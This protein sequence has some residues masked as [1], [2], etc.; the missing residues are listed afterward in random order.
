MSN[1][2][3]ESVNEKARAVER[4]EIEDEDSRHFRFRNIFSQLDQS[5]QIQHPSLTKF[6]FG[7]RNT[8]SVDPPSEL[9]SRV[10]AFLPEISSSNDELTRRAQED[11]SSV[12][13][14]NVTAGGSYIQMNLGL[15]VFEQRGGITRST[16]GNIAAA[17]DQDTEMRLES[18]SSP[19]SGASDSD[20][21]SSDESDSDGS[22]IDIISSSITTFSVRP[23]RPLP[24]RR[25][26][27]PQVV[28]LGDS[29]ASSLGSANSCSSSSEMQH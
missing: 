8:Y 27:R 9:L 1:A 13:I 2:P 11:P 3:P 20:L 4:L 25:S 6:E 28:V 29:A 7:D 16:S 17:E 23:I 18:D 10:K 22:S 5:S 21:D 14:E 24:R 12:D 19:S 26:T 15:G